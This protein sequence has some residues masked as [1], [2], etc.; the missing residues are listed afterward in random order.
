MQDFYKILCKEM[1]KKYM[2]V[3]ETTHDIDLR[4]QELNDR[5]TNTTVRY[6]VDPVQGGGTS[7]ED[8]YLNTIAKRAMLEHNNRVN[9][10]IVSIVE[11]ALKEITDKE[12]DIVIRLYASDEKNVVF[13]L[14]EE[15]H[16]E[17]RNIYYIANKALKTLS[18]KMFGDA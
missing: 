15:Y 6:G 11:K 2:Q 9:K 8:V 18:Y 3:R 4:I 16:Y 1:L 17:K 7:Q 10:S 14:M 12:A 13:K 5:L